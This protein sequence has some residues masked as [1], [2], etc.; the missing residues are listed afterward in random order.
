MK[1]EMY[2][3]GASKGNP[4]HGGWGVLL[5]CPEKIFAKKFVDMVVIQLLITKWKF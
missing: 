5:L 3:D 2:C 1:I 4:G